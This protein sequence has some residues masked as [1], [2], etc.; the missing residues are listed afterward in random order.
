MF[1]KNN[2][3]FQLVLALALLSSCSDNPVDTNNTGTTGGTTT[4]TT[5]EG[6]SDLTS[7]INSIGGVPGINSIAISKDNE[8]IVEE[9]FNGATS[10][11]SFDFDVRSVTKSITSLLTGIAIEKGYLTGVDQKI[12][13]FISPLVDSLDSRFGDITIEQLLTMRAGF[14]W[15]EIAEPSEYPLWVNSENQLDYILSKQFINNPGSIFDYSD[16]A[17]HLMSIVLSQATGMSTLVFADRNLFYPL[18]IYDRQWREDRQN[19]HYGGVGL[20]ISVMHMIKIGQLVLGKGVYN[21]RRVVSEEWINRSTSVQT[22]TN[23]FIPFGSNYGYY[24]WIDNVDG[25]KIFYANGYGGQFIYIVEDLNLII[26][27]K[28]DYRNEPNN[29][30][31]HWLTIMNLLVNNITTALEA[32]E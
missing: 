30:G 28:R 14:E 22:T 21:G 7:A 27:V 9:Y 11:P 18:S 3:I 8:I 12:S 10:E 24:W 20:A 31:T 29:A 17:A 32:G 16:G 4:G 19:F 13:E 6:T 23:N 1:S 26:A 15:H 5:T 2:I 25:H